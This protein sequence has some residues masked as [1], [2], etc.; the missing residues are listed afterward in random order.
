MEYK[1]YTLV[2]ITHTKQHRPAA[3][4]EYLRWQEQN[5]NT[6]LQTLGI[7]SNITYTSGPMV[8]EIKG[9]LV[10]FDTDSII[11]VWRFD[12]FTDREG[13][14]DKDNDP[15]GHLIDDFMLV[16]YIK[17][18]NETMDQK[19][20]VFNTSDPGKNITFFQK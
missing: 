12:F 7:R 6:V 15:V 4:K 10:G 9:R 13:L 14:Y 16:P 18:L 5:F 19:Y 20:A 8:I 3:G 11:R 2:D 17:G 1:L